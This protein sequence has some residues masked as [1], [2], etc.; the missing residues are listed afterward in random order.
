MG[1]DHSYLMVHFTVSVTVCL[2]YK[3]AGD[4]EIIGAMKGVKKVIIFMGI[5]SFS[6]D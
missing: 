2:V 5:T 3:R 4:E 6:R 1:R